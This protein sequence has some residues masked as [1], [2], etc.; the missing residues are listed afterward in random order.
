MTN[1]S[2][3][4]NYKADDDFRRAELYAGQIFVYSPCPGAAK[5]CEFARELIEEAFGSVDPL[6][7]HE[8]ISIEDCAA[9]VYEPISSGGA[10]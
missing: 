2:I 7:A 5:L 1:T 3:Y 6:K 10:K 8:Q 9:I 4:I